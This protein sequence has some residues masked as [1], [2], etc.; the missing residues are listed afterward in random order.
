VSADIEAFII[1]YVK[2][3]REQN[4]AV[5]IGAGLS[6]SAGYVDWPGLLASFAKELGLDAYKET[7]LVSLS[8][9]H[10]NRERDNRSRLTQLLIDNFSDVAEPTESHRVLARLPIRTFWT[11]NYDR[12]IETALSESGK[13]V[14]SKYTVQHLAQTRRGR[15]AVIFKM[16][17]DIELPHEATLTKDDYEKYTSKYQP[18]INALSGDLVE[19][20]FLFLGF[21]FTDPNLDYILSRVRTRFGTHQRAHYWITK[22]RTQITGESTDDFEYAKR[23]QLL[24]SEDLMRFNIKS[25]FIDDYGEINSILKKIADRYRRRTIFI[26]GSAATFG[27]FERTKA[28]EFLTRLAAALVDK[29]FRITTGFGLGVGAPVVTG[30]VQA[31]YSTKDKSIDEQLVLR[32]F[33]IGIKDDAERERTY[34]R[35]RKELIAQAGIAIFCFGN[36]ADGSRVINSPGVRTEF[37]I[38]VKDGLFPIPVGATGFAAKEIWDI[39]LKDFAKFFGS[40]RS[41]EIEPLLKEVGKDVSNLLEILDPLLRLVDILSED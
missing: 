30:A 12:L 2:E 33:P 36:K 18:F 40:S 26:S 3:L 31:I 19:H 23:R 1:E 38:S 17:G 5:F 27:G 15:D 8:Q 28:E 25:L 32:P 29:G 11:T 6:K 16:H 14:D 24:V 7:D 4:A 35:Y 39:A 10:V 34:S 20:T 9:F 21:S 22:K 41:T 37:D 13:R